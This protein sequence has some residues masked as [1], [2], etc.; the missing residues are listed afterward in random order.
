MKRFITL[1]LMAC[2]VFCMLLLAACGNSTSGGPSTQPS[3]PTSVA[4]RQV[5]VTLTDSTITSS[6][7]TFKANIPYDFIVTNKGTA[8]HDFIIRRRIRGPAVTPQTDQGIL[9]IVSSTQLAPGTTLHFSFE[10]PQAS[11][12]SDVQFSEHLAGPGAG[13]GPHIPVQ[14]ES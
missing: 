7:T 13:Q 10:F 3:A 8:A 12:Q 11:I 6:R 5:Q 1:R 9:H 14:I 2:L 4:D